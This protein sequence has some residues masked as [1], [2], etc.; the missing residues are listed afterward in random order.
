MEE[1]RPDILIGYNS[2]HFDIPYLYYRTCNVLGKDMADR[3]SPIG[4]VT[5]SLTR[6]K[7]T[8]KS[9]NFQ[10]VDIK[11]ISSLDYMRMHKK[12]SWAGSVSDT[13]D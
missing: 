6:H 4:K 10:E 13:F 1:I 12:Y 7:N 8:I 3:M 11:G 9:K 5:S 2:D